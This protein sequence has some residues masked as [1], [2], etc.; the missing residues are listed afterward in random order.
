M[1]PAKPSSGSGF[2]GDLEMFRSGLRLLNVR[3]GE[4]IAPTVLGLAATILKL[5]TLVLFLPLVFGLFGGDFSR[6]DR[7]IPL[8]EV[9]PIENTQLLVGILSVTVLIVALARGAC[10]YFASMLVSRRAEEARNLLSGKIIKSYLGYGQQYYDLRR[11][12]HTVAAIRKLPNRG[13][14]LFTFINKLLVSGA[15][16]MLYLTAMAWISLPLTVGVVVALV[17]YLFAF[18]A[19]KN[20]LDKLDDRVEEADD[21]LIAISSDYVLNLPLVRFA[22]AEE[23]VID[24]FSQVHEAGHQARLEET[25]TKAVV[26][27]VR[28]FM[29]IIVLLAFVIVAARF[30]GDVEVASVSR[31]IIFFLIF[32]RSMSH[33]TQILETPEKWKK[34][35]LGTRELFAVLDETDKFIV[36]AGACKYSGLGSGLELRSLS[37]SY[38]EKAPVLTGLSLKIPAGR[39]SVI[40]GATGSGKSTLFRLLLRQYDCPAASIFINGRDIRELETASLI[41][42]IAFAGSHPMFFNDTIR[43]NV[44]FGLETKTGERELREAARKAMALDFIDALEHGFDETIGD[45][46]TLL[47]SGEQQRL[48]LMRVFLRDAD[49]VL[50]DEATSALDSATEAGILAELRDFTKNRTLLM[51]AHRLSNLRPDDHVIVF[52]QGRIVEEGRRDDLLANNGELSRLWKAQR[53]TSA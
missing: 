12:G 34:L 18:D 23:K 43:H 21:R 52:S 16:L 36:P 46:G 4:F 10:A 30:V 8:S 44:T 13:V 22:G 32:R 20:R 39:R 25:H 48:A 14:R 41:H 7:I 45:L 42:N 3:P 31:Y 26:G 2:R 33:F 11:F 35:I 1:V 17:G 28:D 15:A 24:K 51:I 5:A 50:L 38:A 6:L 47:S 9:L 29:T 27:P 19:V 37:F 53:T 49:L 40:V